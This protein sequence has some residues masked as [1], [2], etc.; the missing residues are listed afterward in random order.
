MKK[1]Q[2]AVLPGDGIGP[3]VMPFCCE[4]LDKLAI[5]YGTFGFANEWLQA[6]A[7]CFQKTGESLPQEVLE[8]SRQA[9]AILLGAMGLPSVRY[10]DGTEIAPQLDLR[11]D[12]DLY[13]GVRPVKPM[14]GLPLPLRNADNR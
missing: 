6:G 1:F 2:I 8:S 13:A 7:L 12:M 10:K 3:E 4:L 5:H 14:P 9:D 11:F